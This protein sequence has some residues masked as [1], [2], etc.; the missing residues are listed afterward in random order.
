MLAIQKEKSDKL[1]GLKCADCGTFH[2]KGVVA[3]PGCGGENLAEQESTGKGIIY[4]FTVMKFVPA[5]PHKGRA[6]YV[7]AVVETDDGMRLSAIVETDD[8]DAVKI[9]DK[10]SF[11]EFDP[12][13]G[14][15]FTK[16]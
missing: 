14:F 5:G 3:C 6:P 16:D 11:K 13:T 2:P 1:I 12:E 10:V 8:V 9:G 15:F 7:I 4:T